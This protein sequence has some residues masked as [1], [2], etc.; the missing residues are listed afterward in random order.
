[1]VRELLR[2]KEF[3]LRNQRSCR[4]DQPYPDFI[5]AFILGDG[6]L[7]LP[8]TEARKGSA[9]INPLPYPLLKCIL[10]VLPDLSLYYSK[11]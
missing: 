5:T 8:I 1:M 11:R 6:V 2:K 7:P 4:P 10:P 3:L 9:S